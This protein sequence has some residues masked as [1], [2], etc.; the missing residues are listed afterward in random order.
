MV[1][2]ADHSRTATAARQSYGCHRKSSLVMSLCLAI[3]GC[4]GDHVL[5]DYPASTCDL[6]APPDVVESDTPLA[7]ATFWAADDYE[8]TAFKQLEDRADDAGYRVSVDRMR[9]RVDSQRHISEAFVSQVLPDVF[10]V[11]GGSDVLRWVDGRNAETTAVCALDSL[12]DSYRWSRSYFPEAID[13]VSCDGR[14]YALPVGIHHLNVL[15]YNKR[16]FAELSE[17]ASSRNIVLT[18]PSELASPHDLVTLLERVSQLEATTPTGK[19]IVPLSLGSSSD[20]PLTIVAFENVLLG[21][22]EQAYRN[23]W[24]G[25]LSGVY[26]SRRD[27]L[28]E[29][30]GEMLLVLQR[31]IGH[32]NFAARETWQ[33][34]LR[35]MGRGEALITITGDWGYAQ[36]DGLMLPDVETVTFPGTAGSFVYTPDSFAV[37]RELGKDGS[38]AHGFLH[39]VVEDKRALIAFSNAKHSIPPRHD[40]TEEEISEL[41][42]DSLR[43]SYRQFAACSGGESSCN[44]LLAV[45]GLGPSPGADPCLDEVDALLTL[46]AAGALPSD[47]FLMNRTCSSI[48]PLAREDAKDRL[49]QLLLGVGES[50]FVAGCRD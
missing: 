26:E 1:G 4:S 37:P 12:R 34:A 2:Q 36:L 6:I 21:L 47:E 33:D 30:L 31:L 28:E 32:S 41:G 10:Q 46:A 19:A 35:Q 11:N 40:L 23:L 17:L 38:P 49:L 39:Q 18:P 5:G 14:L 25:G 42:S 7:I 9:T 50:R 16:L 27:S 8:R 20:W 3:A 44:L 29:K 15:F 43:A 45:S 24:M 22:S 48:F 13:P